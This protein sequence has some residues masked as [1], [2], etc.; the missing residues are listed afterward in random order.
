MHKDAQ[1]TEA[2][3]SR[4]KEMGRTEEN[5]AWGDPCVARPGRL[6][7]TVLLRRHQ[8]LPMPFSILKKRSGGAGNSGDSESRKPQLQGDFTRRSI[9]TFNALCVGKDAFTDS[10]KRCCP[11]GAEWYGRMQR[12]HAVHVAH[13]ILRAWAHALRESAGSRYSQQWAS[14]WRD[15]GGLPMNAFPPPRFVNRDIL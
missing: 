10:E 4:I 12:A 8:N 11:C 9:G 13:C 2:H 5:S 3:P 6:G 14:L 1:A 15:G 7:S